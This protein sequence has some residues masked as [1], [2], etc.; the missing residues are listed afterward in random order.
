MAHIDCPDCQIAVDRI[1]RVM[2]EEGQFTANSAFR[3]AEMRQSRIKLMADAKI[4]CE[5][6]KDGEESGEQP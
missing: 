5:C 6:H 1:N 2:L 4:G 3:D